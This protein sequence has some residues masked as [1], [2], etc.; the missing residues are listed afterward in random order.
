M[1]SV[2]SRCLAV[3]SQRVILWW[4][5]FV[6]PPIQSPETRLRPQD[7]H[8][9]AYTFFGCLLRH[10]TPSRDQVMGAWRPARQYAVFL[11]LLVRV[12][13]GLSH[14][15]TPSSSCVGGAIDPKSSVQVKF[16]LPMEM[17][18]LGALGGFI[19]TRRPTVGPP[20]AKPGQRRWHLVNR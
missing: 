12:G 9:Y 2:F 18:I 19:L 6:S 4:A 13:P 14:I 3:C 16:S 7:E 17:G 8:F 15:F 5:L 11:L 20:P 1:L 10:G